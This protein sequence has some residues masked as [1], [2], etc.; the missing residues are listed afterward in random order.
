[1]KAFRPSTKVRKP[2][3][4]DTDVTPIMNLVIVIIPML[5]QMAVFT[6]IALLDY[7]PPA[8]AEE[9]GGDSGGGGGGGGGEVDQKLTL[10]AN[11]R[12]DGIQISMFG[13]TKPGPHFYSIP[14]LPDRSFDWRAFTDSLYSIKVN[15]VGD[16]TGV[17]SVLDETTNQMQTF[18]TYKFVDARDLNITAD[19]EMHFQ[20]VVHA[21]DACRYKELDKNGEI[22]QFELFPQASLKTFQ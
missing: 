21:M 6:K 22:E 15:I 20:N 9:A 13:N 3:V 8:E 4:T 18:N 19:G 1:M 5:L 17:D 16:P 10:V 14:V 12:E 2:S 11:L 7:L